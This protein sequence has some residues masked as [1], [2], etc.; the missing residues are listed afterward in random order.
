D[1]VR[2][3][4]VNRKSCPRP[5]PTCAG[6]CPDPLTIAGGCPPGACRG[7]VPAALGGA[8]GPSTQAAV[9]ACRLARQGPCRAWG[10]STQVAVGACRPA[11]QGL[12]WAWA[13][14]SPALCRTW[15]CG[16]CGPSNCGGG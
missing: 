11:T 12:C 7:R 4:P 6:S 10:L 16:L 2:R 3:E 8:C 9:A 5:C 14:G 15:S 1:L 13:F